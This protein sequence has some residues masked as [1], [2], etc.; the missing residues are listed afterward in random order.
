M[1]AEQITIVVLNWNRRDDTL[2]CVES[3][4][5]A[6]ADGA[7]VLVVDNG[8]RDGSV[9]AIRQRFPDIQVIALPENRGYAGGNNVGI[10]AALEGGADGVLLLNNDARVSPDFLVG[11]LW[12]L[13]IYP[14]AGAVCAAIHRQDRPEMLDVAYAQ[15]RLGQRH[16]VQLLGVNALPGEGFSERRQIEVAVGCCILLTAEAL[17][18]V[19]LFDEEYFAYH[20]DVDWSLRARNAGYQLFYEPLSRV[21]HRG[22]TT[23]SALQ[24]TP[25]ADAERVQYDLPNA[26]ALPWNPART[27]LGARNLWR[28]LRTYATPAERRSFL[29]SCAYEIPL[30]VLAILLRREGWLRLGRFGYRDVAR[31]DVLRSLPREFRTAVRE[32]RLAEMRSYLHGLWDGFRNRPLPLRELGLR[33]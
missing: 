3:L 23:T 25:A 18:T 21:F 32:G 17:R 30:E 27:Y 26:E 33:D 22:S 29:L 24:A 19:G 13:D 6:R 4:A 8:S 5:Q 16:A 2:A 1:K 10:R 20:E 7:R 14:R 15:V 31:I 9:D 28:L 12:T 11:L